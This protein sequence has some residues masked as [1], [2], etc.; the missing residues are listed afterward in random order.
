M[1]SGFYL[2]LAISGIKKNKRMYLPYIFTCIGMVMMFYIIKFLS[3]L[4]LLDYMS[5]GSNIKSMMSFGSG[6]ISIFSVIFL[7]YTNSFLIRKRKKE[8]GLYNILGMGKRNIARILLWETVVIAFVSL[9]FGLILGISLSKLFEL[10]LSNFVKAEINYKFIISSDSIIYTMILFGIIFALILLNSL[11]QVHTANPIALLHSENSGEKPPKANWFLG[12]LGIVIIGVAYYIAVTIESPI[13]AIMWFFV[14]VGLVIVGTYLL[15]ISGSVLLCRILQ[16]NK[17][18]YYKRNHFVSVSSMAYRMKRNGA[19]LASICILGTMVLVMITGSACLY[20]GSEDSLRSNYPRDICI[21]TRGD[22]SDCFS[23]E[24]ISE[25]LKTIMETTKAENIDTKNNINYRLASI[26]GIIKN[27]SFN[28]NAVDYYSLNNGAKTNNLRQI[29]FMPVSDYNNIMGTDYK[30]E[31]AQAMICPIRCDYNY[32]S[33]TIKDCETFS[34]VKTLDNFLDKGINNGIFT[35]S[36]TPSIIMVIPDFNENLKDS[37]TLTDYNGNKMLNINWNCLFDAECDD[38]LQI[39][40]AL[41]ISSELSK[42][43][44]EGADTSISFYIE[45]RAQNRSD[46]YGT[47]GGIFFLGITLSIIF[48]FAAV[49]IIYYKQ[50]SEGYEDQSRFDIMQKVGMTKK[51]IRK[52]INSQMLTVF[53]MPLV[54]AVIHLGFAFPMINRLLMLFN[55]TNLKFLITVAAISVLVFSIFYALIYRITSNVY[56]SIVSGAKESQK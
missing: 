48:T 10:G 20:F 35:M 34:I 26:A 44:E 22:E 11:R 46:Y 13:S 15:F 4:T 16:K 37:M 43:Y 23:D 40:L 51:D 30:L 28:P 8:F 14:A 24:N 25:Y 55:L 17:K 53:Y 49:L 5:G 36:I 50:I 29:F 39:D 18:Y 27:D 54:T 38:N 19:G 3:T 52:S 6:I 33:L 41:K 21:S 2:R 45:S 1:K 31:N 42:N 7:F 9:L 12:L 32:D 47:Y 56:Y